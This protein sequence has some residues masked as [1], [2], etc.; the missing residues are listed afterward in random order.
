MADDYGYHIDHHG[1]LVRPASLLATRAAGLS[2]GAL[3]AATDEA[4]VALAH[5]LRRLTLSAVCDGQYRR[6]YFE[7]VVHDQVAGFA[8]ASGPT[9]LADLAGIPSARVRA[10][11]PGL[12]ASGRLA[13]AEA[14]PVLATVDRNVF[15]T[16]PSP[17][18]L[19]A[20]GSALAS[21]ADV[22]AV[23]A[24]GAALASILRDEIAALAA[25]GVLYVALENPLY[26][27][28]LTVDGRAA[29]TAA[30][31]DVPAVLTALIEA[32]RAVFAGLEVH[33][34]FRVG[35]DLTDAGPLPGTASGYDTTAVAALLDEAPF[36]RISVDYPADPAARFPVALVK[37]GIVVSLGVIDVASPVPE[38]VDDLLGRLDPVLEERGDAD[39]AVA[40]NG[41]FA[42]VADRPLMT[43]AE[44]NA[45]LQLVE[46]A[47]RYYWGNEI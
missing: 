45:K 46:M 27:P 32:D 18:Y 20:A 16:L 35:L 31:I 4:V 13:Q 19:A 17:G 26:V 34:E 43:A 37:P 44:Q 39:V 2:A 1:S 15:V 33:P 47:A 7:S 6:P 5:Q 29:A 3:A 38:A 30:G 40:T 11:V 36:P 23:R 21:S 28:L 22:D 14:A 8:P 10:T 12:A 25:D 41:G 24:A 9:P 42:Q